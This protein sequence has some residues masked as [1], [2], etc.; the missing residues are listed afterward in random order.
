MRQVNVPGKKVGL[1]KKTKCL[2]GLLSDIRLICCQKWTGLTSL[3][4]AQ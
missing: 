4:L 2:R 3:T 1:E